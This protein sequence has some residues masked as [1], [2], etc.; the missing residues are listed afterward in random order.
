MKRFAQSV[1]KPRIDESQRQKLINEIQKP[2]TNFGKMS[3]SIDPQ[4]I[5][6]TKEAQDTYKD[7]KL[8]LFPEIGLTPGYRGRNS[9]K[10]FQSE[11]KSIKELRK[12]R[13]YV[14]RI[15]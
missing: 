6:N 3:P 15:I 13:D 1:K 12:D 11:R 10:V 9:V 4:A 8:S 2:S 7:E 5:L 14:A